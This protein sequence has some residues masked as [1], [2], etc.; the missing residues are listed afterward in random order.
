MKWGLYLLG[1][2][3]VILIGIQFVPNNLPTVETANPGDIIASGIVSD[4]VAAILKT[5]CYSCHSN[6]SIYPWYSYVAPSSWLVAKDVRE[7]REELNFSNWQDYDMMEKLEKL[8]DITIEVGEGTMPMGI[9]T[10]M[11]PT[12]SL[13]DVQREKIIAWAEDAM[14]VV[15]EEEDEEGDE[16]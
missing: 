4:D 16:E 15:L 2:L 13:N 8:D 6:E 12:A 1:G 10:L 9:Y 3:S 14:D 11:H 5:S 7:G